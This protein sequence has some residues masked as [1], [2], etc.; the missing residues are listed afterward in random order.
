MTSLSNVATDV[1][2]ALIFIRGALSLLLN[3]LGSFL[4][5]PQCSPW[6]DHLARWAAYAGLRLREGP[7]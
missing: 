2:L 7:L 3:V 4:G 1:I 6:G 5:N